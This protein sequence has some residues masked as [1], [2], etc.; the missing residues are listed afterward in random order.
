MNLPVYVISL[1]RAADRRE[2]ITALLNADG[3]EYELVDA[4]DGRQLDLNACNPPVNPDKCWK[5]YGVVMPAGAVGCALSLARIC[6][7]I[8]AHG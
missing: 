7:T 6:I 2:S 1:A 3:I 8:S 5:R 4:V